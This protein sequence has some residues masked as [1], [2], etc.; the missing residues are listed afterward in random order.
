MYAI[1]P[2]SVPPPGL[3]MLA[4]SLWKEAFSGSRLGSDASPTDVEGPATLWRHCAL[5]TDNASTAIVAFGIAKKVDSERF[6]PDN[7]TREA[8]LAS[9]M[10]STVPS[11][12]HSAFSALDIAAI[13]QKK[14]HRNT[15][16][17]R[18]RRRH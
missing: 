10:L 1:P 2:S 6:D 13:S 5:A 11:S 14:Q 18:R 17:N 9:I 12:L 4:H 3:L 8:D 15:H 16:E 7:C